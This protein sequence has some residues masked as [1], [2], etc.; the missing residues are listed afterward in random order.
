MFRK[1]RTVQYGER[2]SLTLTT[3]SKHVIPCMNSR[4]PALY[5]WV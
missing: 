3:L 5:N 1:K 2:T 4:S